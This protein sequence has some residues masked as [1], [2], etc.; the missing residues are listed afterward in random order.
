MTLGALLAALGDP[1]SGPPP[2][3]DAAAADRPVKAVAYDSRKAAPGSVFVALK[4]QKA[5]GRAFAAQALG[6]GATAVVAETAPPPDVTA[7]WIVVRDARLA[8][9]RLAAAFYGHPSRDLAVIGITGT[10]GKTT[11]A[12][13]VSALFEAAAVRCG[14]LGTIV[15]RAGAEERAADR[16]T[17]E[18]VDVQQLLR[19][20]VSRQ[21]GACAMEVSSHAL[22][23][24][25]VDETRFAAA[26]FTNLT[27]DHLDFHGD[28]ES[29]F[30]AKR[31]LFEMLGPDAA[32]VIN[33]DDPRGAS[34]AGLG[35]RTLTYAI[36]R[37]AD[38]YPSKLTQT[39]RGLAFE[40]ITPAGSIEVRSRLVGRPNIYNTLAAIGAAVACGLPNDAVARGIAALEG[41]PGRFQ[42]VSGEGDDITVVVDYAHTDDALKNLLE[43]ARPLA[44]ARLITVLGAGGDRDRTKRP[45]MGHVAARLS[46][47]VILTSDNPRS[48]DPAAIIEEI[49]RGVAVPAERTRP[50]DSRESQANYTP[51]TATAHLAI[52]D[53]ALAVERAIALARPD[54]VVLIA[55]KGHEKYQV[56]GD[57]EIPFDDV[58]VARRAL[59]RRRSGRG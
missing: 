1:V 23:L 18:S 28:L 44:T 3:L 51:P 53:R 55:G 54:D 52:T 57:R 37:P 21:C 5:D 14:M 20:M 41:V 9:A 36:D 15:Y 2:S 34:L 42:I 32:A 13:L 26:V 50:A 25:R 24:R 22:A 45:L 43:T 49:R 47:L 17:P 4:G 33:I 11:T 8:M 48:E 6:K 39:I 38:I 27:R 19:E 35:G 16:T 40:A 56:I 10:N 29:Y 59:E 58:D 12:Y 30:A 31:R 46:D 7:P